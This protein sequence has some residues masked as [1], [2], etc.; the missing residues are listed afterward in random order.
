MVSR[1]KNKIYINAQNQ[2]TSRPKERSSKT[3]WQLEVLK[4]GVGVLQHFSPRKASEIVWD[5]FTK[6]GKS[7]FT[8]PQKLL[9]EQARLEVVYYLGYKIC[10]YTWGKSEKRIL[11]SHGWNSKIADFRRLIQAFVNQGY[12]VEGMDM[13]AH[14]QSDGSRTALPEFR[15]ILKN[16]YVQHGPFEA[17]IGYSLGGMAAGIMLSELAPSFHPKHLYL[18]ASPSHTRYFFKDIIED[19]GYK[20][21]VYHEMC[22]L[23][24]DRYKESVDYFDLRNKAKVFK[25]MNV[26]LIYDV[27]DKT[28][29]I[30][31]GIELHDAFEDASFI[32]TSGLGHYQ[33]I[34]YH[35]VIDYILSSIADRHE[36]ISSE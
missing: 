3:S 14:G 29:G 32:Q 30:D 33:V 35:E 17:V 27:D 15:D 6:P 11:L 2:D 13:K 25:H 31:R 1:R 9:L 10:T 4:K 16:Y 19:L 12:Q 34:S 5:Q 22:Q 26:H 20:E 8:D 23:V 21:E 36:L 18:I 7:R 24:Q 28:V